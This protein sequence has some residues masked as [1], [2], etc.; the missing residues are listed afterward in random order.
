MY[1]LVSMETEK[2]NICD[3]T[4]KMSSFFS[5]VVKTRHFILGLN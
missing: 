4:P 2:K 5:P 1:V 3:K